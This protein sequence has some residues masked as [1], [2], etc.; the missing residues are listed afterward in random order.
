MTTA[1]LEKNAPHLR[2]YIVQR[3]KKIDVYSGAGALMQMHSADEGGGERLRERNS[4][5][6]FL[7]LLENIN[8]LY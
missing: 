7:V 5:V 3:K 4:C 8:C 1:E 2:S 6:I